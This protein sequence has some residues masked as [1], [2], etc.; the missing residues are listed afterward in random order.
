MKTL[1]DPRAYTPFSSNPLVV[2]AERAAKAGSALQQQDAGGLL[3]S[4]LRE[5][6]DAGNDA[7]IE[8]ALAEATSRSVRE[9][10]TCALEAVLEARDEA[11]LVMRVFA[12][13]LLIV[14]GGRGLAVVPGVV[15]DVGELQNLFEKHGALGQ[16]KNFGLGNALTT[17]ERLA[18]VK[19]GMLYRLTRGLGQAG[20]R[21][22]DL[23][24]QDIELDSG[25]ERVHLRFLAGAA[26]TPA[27]A[28][29]FTETA[30]NI[31]AWGLPFTLVLAEQLGQ[32][33]LSLLPIPRPPMNPQRALE[34][35]RFAL[36]EMEFQ[37]FLSNALRRFRARVGDPDATVA[38]YS[39]GSVRINLGSPFD[40]SLAC[41]YRWPLYPEDNL[42]AVGNS[43]FGLLA[44]CRLE[45]VRV[46][47]TVWLAKVASH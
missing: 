9:T 36:R 12:I 5:A 28:P 4:R 16:S 47:E 37:L 38:S 2:A 18:S 17:A 1:P 45:T 43:I 11:G 46:A 13:P 10:I 23:A 6:L 20:F 32:E 15:P 26:V 44:E 7:R 3:L 39:D 8:E 25:E 30:G 27:N 22:P 21:A 14:T 34:T 31:G 19:P 35:G 24:P 41:E 33:G 40:A 29:G 42:G